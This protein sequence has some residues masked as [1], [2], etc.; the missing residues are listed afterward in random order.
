MSTPTDP[1]TLDSANPGS[2]QSISTRRSTT[3]GDTLLAVA[4]RD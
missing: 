3:A 2:L 1:A 4:S